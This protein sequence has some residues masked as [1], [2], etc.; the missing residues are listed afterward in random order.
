MTIRIEAEEIVRTGP[1]EVFALID[2]FS[3]MPDW[4]STC[5]KIEKVGHGPNAPGDRLKYSTRERQGNKA[6]V[7]HYEGR[8]L[9]RVPGERLSLRIE[10]RGMFSTR[11]FRLIP[12]SRGTRIRMTLDL[13]PRTW[14]TRLGNRFL[15][16]TIRHAVERMAAEDLKNLAS[17]LDHHRQG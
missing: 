8:I 13:E 12:V 6:L 17:L 10:N 11:E 9:E 5:G 1:R 2:D 4:N 14:L 7:G 3:R 16:R 15:G